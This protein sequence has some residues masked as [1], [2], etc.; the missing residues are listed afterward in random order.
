MSTFGNGSSSPMP[1][2]KMVFLKTRFKGYAGAPWL[3]DA[4]FLAQS[5]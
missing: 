4:R 5:N 2:T 3:M 1:L